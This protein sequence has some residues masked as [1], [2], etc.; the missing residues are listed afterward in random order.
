MAGS[1]E[2]SLPLRHVAIVM[3]G[4][5]RWAD[6]HLLPRL[7]GHKAGVQTL[8]NLVKHV[9]Q[10]GLKYMTVYAFSSEN[11][12]RGADE[13]DYLMSLFAEVLQKELIEL[14]ANNVR[15]AFIGD[16]AGMPAELVK[17]LAKATF[18]TSENTGLRLQV[19]LN[20]G[21]RLEITEAVRRIAKEVE[22]GQLKP[23]AVNTELIAS[24]L[25][26][27]DLP[28]P[29]L[30]IRTGGEMRLSNYLLWQAAYA[31]LYVTPT[32]WPDFTA[33]EFDQAIQN[34]SQRQR[35]YGR[36]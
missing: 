26:T 6:C 23:E 36:D 22:D 31:E 18:K 19:A 16:L 33:S 28:D 35:R 4:N 30:I 17:G 32:M 27:H 21:S 11:W 14:A 13:V 3:D 10:R 2:S 20:Y 12:Q 5:R 8:K 24:Y 15:L 9:S 1:P 25:Y 7:A 34:Y 29:D